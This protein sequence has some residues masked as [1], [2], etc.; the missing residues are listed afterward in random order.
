MDIDVS[1]PAR[2]ATIFQL[3]RIFAHRGSDSGP[4]GRHAIRYLTKSEAEELEQLSAIVE[5]LRAATHRRMYI[6]RTRSPVDIK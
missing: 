6:T 4:V 5:I 2:L 3:S 1:S